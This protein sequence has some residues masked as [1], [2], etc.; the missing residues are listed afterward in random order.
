VE[1]ALVHFEPAVE[2][3]REELFV[4]GTAEGLIAAKPDE[5]THPAIVYPERGQIIAIDPDI[6]EALQR[7]PFEAIGARP[8][9][10]WRLNGEP[11]RE[12]ALW[13]PQPG[14]WQLSL[15]DVNGE[16]LDSVQFEVRGSVAAPPA[17]R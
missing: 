15:H 14:R 10:Q 3:V 7:V 13:R 2:A 17:E 6:P 16:Q 4:E 12:G 9:S 8:Q 1:T 5:K 11:V